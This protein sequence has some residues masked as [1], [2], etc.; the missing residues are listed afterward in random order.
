MGKVKVGLYFYLIADILTKV[1]Q[2]C[3]LSSPLPN[4]SF[5]PNPLNLIGRH[6]NQK[7]KFAKKI[8]KNHLL[9]SNKGE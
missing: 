2:N 6:G 8:L 3:S 9:R 1:L 5:L 7:A 4:I